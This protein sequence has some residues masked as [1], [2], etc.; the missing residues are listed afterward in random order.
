MLCEPNYII[1]TVIVAECKTKTSAFCYKLCC[2]SS[3]TIILAIP[4]LDILKNYTL[5]I[6]IFKIL[7]L[8]ILPKSKEL[9]IL[10]IN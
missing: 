5:W 8:S 7:F 2:C 10:K 3:K 6:D 1:L 4:N 9:H